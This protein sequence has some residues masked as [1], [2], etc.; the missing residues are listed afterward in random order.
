MQLLIKMIFLSNAS[1]CLFLTILSGERVR[2]RGRRRGVRERR[3]ERARERERELSHVVKSVA[4]RV[5]N[6][7]A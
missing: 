5:E 7:E 2:E 4:V 3:R 1:T 6:E